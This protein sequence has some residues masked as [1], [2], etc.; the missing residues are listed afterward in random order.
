MK[1]ILTQKVI[2]EN[3]AAKKLSKYVSGFDYIDKIFIFS[4]ATTGG[5]CTISHATVVGAPIGIAI[6]AFT[7]VFSLAT[8]II[9]NC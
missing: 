7:I 6:A 2:K 8:E 5:V 9:T 1:V 4:G 3:Y